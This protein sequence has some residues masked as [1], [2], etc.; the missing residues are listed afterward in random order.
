MKKRDLAVMVLLTAASLAFSGCT[1]KKDNVA[2][3]DS[4]VSAIDV[5]SDEEQEKV[6]EDLFDIN[7]KVSIKIDVSDEELAK[8]QEDYFAYMKKHSKSP[9]Y[10]K[11]DKVTI[12]INDDVYELNDVGI[13]MKGNTSRTD[14]YSDYKGMYNLIHLKLSFDE[15]FENEDYYGDDAVKWDDEES[16]NDRK[17]RTFATLDGLELKWNKN[18][19]NAYVRQYYSYEMFRN[20]D[21][22]APNNSFANIQLGDEN[23]GVYFINEPIDKKF[24]ERNLPE[25][26][27]GGDLYKGGWTNSPANYTNSMTY[28]IDDRDSGEDYNMSL[29]T[30]KSTSNHEQMEKLIDVLN[31]PD[32]TA[33]SMSEVI[34]VD[35][36][37]KFAAVSYFL[38]NPDDF[39]NNYNNHYVYF[40]K[41]S[42]KAIFIP[43]DYDRTL[44]IVHSYN[45][46]ATGMTEASP[47]SEFAEGS[48]RKQNN[49]L[50]IHS[51]L[52][53]GFFVEEYK[54]VL[55]EIA[56][57]DW[58]TPER[59]EKEYEIVKSNYEDVAVFDKKFENVLN[60]RLSFSLDGEF[61][62]A[63]DNYNMSV[64]EYM[65]RIMDTYKTVIAQL[66][67]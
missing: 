34:D 38:G 22:L 49:P 62:Y 15:T 2:P 39:R 53:E 55:K 27:W 67:E 32:I 21:V 36:F 5:M 56:D 51:I 31:S 41:S 23:V 48:G 10:R 19:D 42:G 45:P 50:Y 47:F 58:M 43:Y 65:T 20:F 44:G 63:E 59:I 28:G 16:L 33:E 64:E 37:S 1:S 57:S 12:T 40:L 7:N 61:A 26:E 46:D 25:E 4:N 18:Y 24:I 60:D 54:N 29:K 14:F 3:A 8:I 13:R 9:I 30:N 11:A 52:S 17:K 6:Y 66:Q 35:E